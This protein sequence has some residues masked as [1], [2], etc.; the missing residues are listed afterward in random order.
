MSSLT[1]YSSQLF[2]EPVWLSSVWAN[3]ERWICA[4]PSILATSPPTPPQVLLLLKQIIVCCNVWIYADQTSETM[5]W[6]GVVNHS[7][8]WYLNRELRNHNEGYCI[9]SGGPC[10]QRLECWAFHC[11]WMQTQKSK[12]LFAC[13]SD[14]VQS[15]AWRQIW[16][17]SKLTTPTPSIS[18][19]HIVPSVLCH[20]SICLLSSH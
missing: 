15:I 7:S 14:F 20:A 18:H 4:L 11:K 16:T 6:S 12:R 17:E 3:W 1:N 5:V 8:M 9:T 13:A 2:S 19:L 10:I